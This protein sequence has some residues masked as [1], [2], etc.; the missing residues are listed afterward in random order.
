MKKLILILGILFS[1]L[2]HSQTGTTVAG[3]F[4]ANTAVK[5]NL[6]TRVVVQDS[7]SKEYRWIL[8]SSLGITSSLFARAVVERNSIYVCFK[9][10]VFLV[11]MYNKYIWAMSVF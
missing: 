8:K 11:K 1:G 3:K 7:I 5:D 4:K 2:I 10:L 9:A 6:A